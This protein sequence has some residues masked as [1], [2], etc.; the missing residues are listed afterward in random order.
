MQAACDRFDSL[1]LRRAGR[2]TRALK[3]GKIRS[4]SRKIFYG[5]R[6]QPIAT[7]QIDEYAIGFLPTLCCIFSLLTRWEVREG[8]M[9]VAPI[10]A[11][12]GKEKRLPRSNIIVYCTQQ[13]CG[14]FQVA[15]AIHGP[16][17][18]GSLRSRGSA[19]L[20]IHRILVGPPN[21]LPATIQQPCGWF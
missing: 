10:S 19:V 14:W 11:P 3:G 15:R 12:V 7:Q 16:S 20:P 5:H 13:A 1:E 9:R 6:I 8:C 21:P 2:R 4:D 17:P 18:S